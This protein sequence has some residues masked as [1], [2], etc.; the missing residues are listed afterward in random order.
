MNDFINFIFVEIC[1][2]ITWIFINF[3]KITPNGSIVD[4]TTIIWQHRKGYKQGLIS[5][6][7]GMFNVHEVYSHVRDYFIIV[8]WDLIMETCLAADTTWLSYSKNGDF[9]MVIWDLA[10]EVHSAVWCWRYSVVLFL[11]EAT[12]LWAFGIL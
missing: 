12:L 5:S 11:K 3:N 4:K 9:I 6:T 8:S 10:E 7:C 1:Y 2:I